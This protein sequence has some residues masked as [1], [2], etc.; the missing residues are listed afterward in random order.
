MIEVLNIEVNQLRLVLKAIEKFDTL[1][2]AAEALGISLRQLHLLKEYYKI[3]LVNGHY[4]TKFKF[5]VEIE[6]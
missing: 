3:E 1:D 6:F 2:K 5:H 4:K